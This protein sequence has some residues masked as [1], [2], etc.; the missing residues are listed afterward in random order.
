MR[1]FKLILIV[2]CFVFSSVSKADISIVRDGTPW[3]VKVVV[4]KVIA[5]EDANKLEKYFTEYDKTSTMP[6]TVMVFLDSPGGSIEAALKIGRLFRAKKAWVNIHPNKICYSSCVYLL[7]GGES[8]VVWNDAKVGIHRAYEPNDKNTSITAQK[9]KY[10]KLGLKIKEYLSEVNIPVRVYD[11]S[12][13]INPENMKILNEK[14]LEDYGLNRDDPYA[15]EAYS[16]AQAQRLGISRMEYMNRKN[17]V[18][19][20]CKLNMNSKDPFGNRVRCELDV[21]A[22]RR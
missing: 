1:N 11:D 16:V 2:L 13:Y 4:E 12:L 20:I 3:G 8:R 17:K 19:E 14:E 21:L 15:D 5:L 22:G 10:E 18:N 6:P 7:A 9:Q